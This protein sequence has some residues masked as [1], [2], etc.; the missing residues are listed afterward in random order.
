MKLADIT[1]VFRKKPL[2][3]TNYRL[4]NVLPPIS[5]IYEKLLQKQINDYIEIILSPYLCGYRK[6]YSNQHALKCPDTINHELLIAK[7]Q[8]HG[9]EK[10]AL[11]LLFK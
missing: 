6:G 10:S 2:D 9:F 11:K 8:A 5:K 3:K 4:V 7:S 1:P